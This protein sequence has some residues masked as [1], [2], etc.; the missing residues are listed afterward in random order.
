MRVRPDSSPLNMPPRAV[1]PMRRRRQ[2][3]QQQR[4][5]VGPTKA[6]A[7]PILA[8][9]VGPPP[10][11]RHLLPPGHQPRAAS[12]GD[13]VSMQA[14]PRARIGHHFAPSGQG[15]GRGEKGEYLWKCPPCSLHLALSR[16]GP[17]RGP[18]HP[19]SISGILLPSF[20]M[21]IIFCILPAI[22]RGMA[23][24]ARRTMIPPRRPPAGQRAHI[25]RTWTRSSGFPPFVLSPCCSRGW[26]VTSVL[27]PGLT[28]QLPLLS[29]V[30]PPTTQACM[31]AWSPASPPPHK[32]HW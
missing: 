20:I 9:T 24:S 8:F 10:D 7:G 23:R 18:H 22:M 32:S 14:G 15:Q 16:P 6:P 13:E 26:Q 5:S 30:P 28:C 11:P 17:R 19:P 4:A 21:A 1:G 3:D 12:A 27:E 25:L 31:G 29:Q 2:S